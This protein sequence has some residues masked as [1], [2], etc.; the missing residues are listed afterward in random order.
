MALA[1]YGSELSVRQTNKLLA[2]QSTAYH[3]SGTSQG[4]PILV[5]TVAKLDGALIE[6]VQLINDAINGNIRYIVV[7][8]IV[9]T[10][11]GIWSKGFWL[12]EAVVCSSNRFAVTNCQR[13]PRREELSMNPRRL[14][15]RL[16]LFCSPLEKHDQAVDRP[17]DQY[18]PRVNTTA[19]KPATSQ[20]SGPRKSSTTLRFF[21]LNSLRAHFLDKL[22][23]DCR[24]GLDRTPRH[25]G[26]HRYALHFS[27]WRSSWCR[28]GKFPSRGRGIM[29][30]VATCRLKYAALSVRP[31]PCGAA[32]AR[33]AHAHTLT[34][35]YRRAALHSPEGDA[36]TCS[37]PGPVLARSAPA[38]VAVVV[39]L[40]SVHADGDEAGHTIAAAP[41]RRSI[42]AAPQARRRG[43]GRPPV[44]RIPCMT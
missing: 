2:C 16:Y 43:H 35:P 32:P 12:G 10:P 33:A 40:P 30:M 27:P 41:R 8:F 9:G 25:C 4:Q 42:I 44:C 23:E 20:L 7:G 6:T 18:A 17:A 24:V 22:R 39:V 38:V 29:A 36:T 13:L 15:S 3:D 19:S 26:E 28:A 1:T 14:S 34:P 5:V 11:L 37:G 21:D 31:L